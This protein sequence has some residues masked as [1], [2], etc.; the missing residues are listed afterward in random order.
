MPQNF[1]RV[2]AWHLRTHPP[3]CTQAMKIADL[4]TH[5]RSLMNAYANSLLCIFFQ[6]SRIISPNNLVWPGLR[7]CLSHLSFVSLFR[8]LAAAFPQSLFMWEL[9]EW[10]LDPFTAPLL[11][12]RKAAHFCVMPPYI[13]PP[14]GTGLPPTGATIF[15]TRRGEL[16]EKNPNKPPKRNTLLQSYSTLLCCAPNSAREQEYCLF[17]QLLMLACTAW[18]DSH[19]HTN[20][21]DE[22]SDGTCQ[23]LLVKSQ[24]RVC[25][26][27]GGSP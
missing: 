2:P 6:R 26:S 18:S 5:K 13:H 8:W 16:T 24:K 20:T 10:R 1:W 19:I 7:T 17:W 21:K 11:W 14:G 22:G 27:A 3:S 15:L 9:Q 12:Q 23:S 4:R 25:F